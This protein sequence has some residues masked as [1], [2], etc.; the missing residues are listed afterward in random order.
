MC[1]YDI[2]FAVRQ[3]DLHNVEVKL[4]KPCCESLVVDLEAPEVL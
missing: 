3:T 4:A 1:E 2:N